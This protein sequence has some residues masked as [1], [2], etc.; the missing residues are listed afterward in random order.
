MKIAV[1][2]TQLSG[3]LNACLRELAKLED[4]QVLVSHFASSSEAPFDSDQFKWIKFRYEWQN[5][6]DKVSL[7]NELREHQPDVILVSSWHI[8]EYRYVLKQF[9]GKA[10]CCHFTTRSQRDT[11]ARN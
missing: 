8:S 9:T 1:L 7:L 3:Y 5:H 6:I 11:Q 4:V 2:W 10:R